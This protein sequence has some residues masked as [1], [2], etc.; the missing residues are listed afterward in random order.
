MKRFVLLSFAALAANSA[1]AAA[2]PEAASAALWRGLSHPPGVAADTGALSRLFH[3][4]SVVIGARYRGDTPTLSVDKGSDFLARMRQARPTGFHECE[5]AREVKRHDRF[6]T[7]Y[8]VVES[9]TDP[10]A[11]KAD[12]VG[13]NS[14]QLYQSEEGW[15]I[16]SLYYHVGKPGAPVPLGSGRSGVCLG[17]RT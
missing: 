5:V 14:I 1:W 11:A 4:D 17:E 9:R 10:K 13:V 2:T 8:S 16:V 7:V 12:F 15:Q 3:P 6:A